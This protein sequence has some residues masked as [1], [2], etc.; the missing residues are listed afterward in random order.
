[1]KAKPIRR[2]DGIRTTGEQ[3]ALKHVAV[4]ELGHA[5]G[6]LNQGVTIEKVVLYPGGQSPDGKHMHGECLPRL[7]N[8]YD[9]DQETQ[10]KYIVALLCGPAAV[11]V[12]LKQALD[13]GDNCDRDSACQLA[14]A[15]GLA[16]EW[17]SLG[18]E[19][20]DIV[21]SRKDAI[22]TLAERLAGD[23]CSPMPAG[24]LTTLKT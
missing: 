12:V 7:G 23:P 13:K 10:R 8:A 16:P 15:A 5:A 24:E 20:E 2:G 4:H 14:C 1:M 22:S 9:E 17:T 11:R 21:C 3:K 18:A 19:A 6:M